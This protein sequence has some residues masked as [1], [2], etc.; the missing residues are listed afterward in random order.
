[1]AKKIKAVPVDEI[2]GNHPGSHPAPSAVKAKGDAAVLAGLPARVAELEGDL[3]RIVDLLVK[4]DLDSAK[5][6]EILSKRQGKA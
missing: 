6:R 5:F 2:P 3:A 1:M 4:G